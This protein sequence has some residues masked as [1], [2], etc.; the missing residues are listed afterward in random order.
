MLEEN[1]VLVVG[2]TGRTGRRVVQELLNKAYEVRVIARTPHKLSE[3]ILNHPRLRLIE[4]VILDFT[5]LELDACVR[6]CKAVVSCLGHVLSLHG[7]YGAPQMLCT[8]A[9]RRLCEAIERTSPHGTTKFILMNSIGVNNP[10][11]NEVRSWLDRAVLNTLRITVPIQR[12]NEFAARYLA[13]NVGESHPC[14]QWCVVR[15]DSLVNDDVSEYVTETHPTTHLF[16]GRP[17]ARANV[18]HFMTRLITEKQT[19]NQWKFQ[20]PVLSNRPTQPLAE[21]V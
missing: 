4:G 15:P 10:K 1:I 18:A 20:M 13:L 6:G 21:A 8:D 19:W 16:Q 7:I 5:D 14:I 2:A 11:G 12:D 9:T 3:D 17:T